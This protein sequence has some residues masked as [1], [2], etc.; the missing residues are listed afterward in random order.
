MPLTFS[1]DPAVIIT[2][3]SRYASAIHSFYLGSK[4]LG[5]FTVNALLCIAQT[6]NFFVDVMLPKLLITS[7]RPASTPF[8][9][10]TRIVPVMGFDTP[11]KFESSC[12]G[13][14]NFFTVLVKK[15]IPVLLLRPPAVTVQR[16]SRKQDVSVRVPIALVVDRDIS[17]HPAL[18][19]VF[20]HVLLYHSDMGF[21]VKLFRQGNDD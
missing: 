9:N 12:D 14:K 16:P 15:V 11:A 6:T 17:T 1:Y 3:I 5:G 10:S 21:G 20:L 8:L 18:N 2:T 7:F 4:V 19:K 13:I